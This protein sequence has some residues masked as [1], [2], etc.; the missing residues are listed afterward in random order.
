LSALVGKEAEVATTKDVLNMVAAFNG[1][2]VVGSEPEL[3]LGVWR[4]WHKQR[5]VFAPG[6]SMKTMAV[7]KRLVRQKDLPAPPHRLLERVLRYW[8][9]FRPWAKRTYSKGWMFKVEPDP[10]TLACQPETLVGWWAE[11]D[12]IAAESKFSENG[13]SMAKANAAYEAAKAKMKPTAVPK[14]PDPPLAPAATAKDEVAEEPA[15]LSMDT[16]VKKK[17]LVFE[18]FFAQVSKKEK[19]V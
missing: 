3:L 5:G 2:P 9:E 10:F 16:F 6:W 12:K 19:K 11:A 17:P 4:E 13:F 1:K 7:W 18:D 15:E 8:D 14:P